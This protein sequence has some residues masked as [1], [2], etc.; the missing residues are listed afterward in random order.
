MAEPQGV[1]KVTKSGNTL[2]L[3]LQN[4]YRFTDRDLADLMPQVIRAVYKARAASTRTKPVITKKAA[5]K[6]ITNG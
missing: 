2:D 5:E 1:I 4:G 6:E 3:T